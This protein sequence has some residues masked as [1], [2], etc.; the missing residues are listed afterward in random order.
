MSIPT[1]SP[2]VI[3]ARM[4]HQV[5]ELA[6]LLATLALIL[7]AGLLLSL[8]L[9]YL[10]TW[11]VRSIGLEETAERAGVARVLYAVGLRRGV[12]LVAGDLV[13]VLG[14][15]I[16]LALMAELAGLAGVATAVAAIA[17]F[18]PSLF[19]ALG[20]LLLGALLAQTLSSVINAMG[21]RSGELEAPS[22]AAR[23]AYY[24]ILA[25]A[26][27]SAAEQ[28]GLATSLVHTLLGVGAA[29]VGFT[30]ALTLALGSRKVIADVIARHYVMVLCPVG[31]D[32]EVQLPQ[33]ASIRGEIVRYSTTSAV[34]RDAEGRAC[35]LP[36]SLLREQA[37]WIQD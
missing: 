15:T 27:V 12:A 36:C 4:S 3:W 29:A 22:L 34:V 6:P 1:P 26:G 8:G 32:I 11:L 10:A 5:V 9:R 23:A 18:I 21:G 31:T 24:S 2:H 25:I 13:A 33:G 37:V 17:R 20:I 35:V 16:T 14:V 19:A 30:V 28:I 7:L